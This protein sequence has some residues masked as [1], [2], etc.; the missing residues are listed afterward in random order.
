MRP[1]PTAASLGP[2]SMT[3][4]QGYPLTGFTIIQRRNHAARQ[5]KSTVTCDTGTPDCRVRSQRHCRLAVCYYG[6]KWSAGLGVLAVINIEGDSP[7]SCHAPQPHC[8]VQIKG[9]AVTM[10]CAV[11]KS[12]NRLTCS[13]VALL[14]LHQIEALKHC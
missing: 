5:V 13:S 9:L 6:A 10:P 3:W 8:I 4:F 7:S 11:M 2:K 12:P 1:A 14:M